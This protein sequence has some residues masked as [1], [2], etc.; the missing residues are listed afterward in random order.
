VPEA[1]SI[2]ELPPLEHGGEDARQGF[3]L[4]DHVAAA[5][6]IRM[7]SD[8][9]LSEVWCENQDDITL[10]RKGDEGRRVQF[11]QVK[12]ADLDH[13]WSVAALCE[14]KDQRLGTS[15]LER[16]LAYDRCKERCSFKLITALRVNSELDALTAAPGS[17]RRERESAALGSLSEAI[18][19][20]LGRIRSPNEH[21]VDWWICNAQWA[22]VHSIEAVSNRNRLELQSAI[23][24]RGEYVAQDQLYEVYTSLVSLVWRAAL[25]R[26]KDD[27][28]AKRITKS[29][30]FS[31]LEKKLQT[32]LHSAVGECQK[33]RN[34]ME[35]ASLPSDTI[36]VAQESR[37][38]YRREVLSQRYLSIDDRKLVEAEVAARMHTLLAELDSGDSAQS[39]R[40]FHKVCLHELDRVLGGLHCAAPPP[41][42]F[43]Q[44]CMYS[45]TGRCTHRFTKASA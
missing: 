36:L 29:M 44:G 32:L 4:Q 14:R 10:I 35:D 30:L 25:T 31:W 7:L 5:F 8:P 18:V 45:I 42:A 3:G 9:N 1:A 11:V 28:Q 26:F 12:G 15:I 37:S 38:F 20:R 41:L 13:H 6:C 33:L 27:P 2:F 21:G 17:E 34:K 39:G 40:E 23:E 19:A 43:L 16:S 22:V 24:A